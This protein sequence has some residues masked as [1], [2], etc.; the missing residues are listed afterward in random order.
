MN[1]GSALVNGYDARRRTSRYSGA[2]H[3]EIV[4]KVERGELKQDLRQVTELRL[5]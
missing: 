5:N 3:V 4:K 2:H 1:P